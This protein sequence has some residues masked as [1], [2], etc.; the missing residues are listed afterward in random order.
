MG[1]E[2]C[3]VLLLVSDINPSNF[4]SLRENM[5]ACM[6]YSASRDVSH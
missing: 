4:K 6:P 1:A 3:Q 5:R 2:I